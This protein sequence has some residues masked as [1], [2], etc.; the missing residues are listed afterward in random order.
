[1]LDRIGFAAAGAAAAAMRSTRGRRRSVDIVEDHGK[2]QGK[3]PPLVA[4]GIP[5]PGQCELSVSRKSFYLCLMMCPPRKR[6]DFPRDDALGGDFHFTLRPEQFK[7]NSD[8]LF[9]GESASDHGTKPFEWPVEHS[10]LIALFD[11]RRNLDRF[12]IT[13]EFA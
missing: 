1:M 9:R 8:T 10:H 2:N 11:L 6:V 7:Q 12:V 13:G 5:R 4:G 3:L